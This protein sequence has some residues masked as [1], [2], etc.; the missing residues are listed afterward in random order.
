MR[1]H[2]ETDYNPGGSPWTG[3]KMLITML[4]FFGVIIAVNLAMAWLAVRDFRGVI[5][6]SGYVA[7]QDFNA[8]SARLAAQAA[9]GWAI[10]ADAAG[11]AP[12]LRFAEADGRPITDL[13]LT[14]R[15]LRNGDGRA[16][17]ALTLVETAPGLYVANETLAAGGWKLAV[18]AE[19]H[20]PRYA[21]TL[22]LF[23]SPGE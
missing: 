1:Q 7:S 17:T 2:P 9:R 10:D 4:A 22:D 3:R 14:A 8:D 16:D 5:V 6:D 19:G 20:G 13:S 18:I 21:T 23:I 15:A 12:M 11:R